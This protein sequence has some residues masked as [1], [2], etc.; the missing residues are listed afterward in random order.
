MFPVSGSPSPSVSA[1]GRTESHVPFAGELSVARTAPVELRS[2][3]IR[4]YWFCT[5][6]SVRSNRS[7]PFPV[8]VTVKV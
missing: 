2:S 5:M 6:R 8:L 3:T 1:A 7:V 4:L